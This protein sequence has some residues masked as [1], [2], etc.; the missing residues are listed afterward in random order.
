MFF[1]H[2]F[3]V[4]GHERFHLFH[5]SKNDLISFCKHYSLL[6]PNYEEN[7]WKYF[8][9]D[10]ESAF[11]DGRIMFS[12]TDNTP[13]F[14]IKNIDNYEIDRLLLT[15]WHGDMHSTKGGF[16][17]RLMQYQN[18]LYVQEMY[19]VNEIFCITPYDIESLIPVMNICEKYEI[20]N[21]TNKK[22]LS[23]FSQEIDYDDFKE[24]NWLI[25]NFY[26][27]EFLRR[28]EGT[29][30][31]PLR[32][33]RCH[34]VFIN[35][36]WDDFKKSF[37]SSKKFEKNHIVILIRSGDVFIDKYGNQTKTE[38]NDRYKQPTLK[39]YE[40]IIL[41]ETPDKIYIVCSDNNAPIISELQNRFNN[42]ELRTGYSIIDDIN[43]LIECEKIVLS[44][45]KFGWTVCNLSDT[46]RQ[47]Y[48][49]NFSIETDKN[50][51]AIAKKY[52]VNII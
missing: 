31:E 27:I 46:I 8:S 6:H 43:F 4:D 15:G 26:D 11:N 13:Y 35:D 41:G 39:F 18:L 32:P 49:D 44:N 25:G 33:H 45:S 10:A 36:F 40:K 30:S 21:V 34:A 23:Y 48:V 47:V 38:V 1:K 14:F 5:H 50:S 42:V 22:N 51:R 12:E 24:H 37:F 16:S 52:E 28:V 9:E 29:A 2:D 19:G 17:S 7:Y 20:K 3:F